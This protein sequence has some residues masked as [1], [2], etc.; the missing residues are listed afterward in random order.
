[1]DPILI[2]GLLLSFLA[3]VVATLIDGGQDL[4]ELAK[5]RY[6]AASPR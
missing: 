1:M 4:P 3:I 5:Y 6:D 2:G